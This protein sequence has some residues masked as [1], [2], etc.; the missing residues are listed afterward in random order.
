MYIYLVDD[1]HSA[2]A[3]W[4]LVLSYSNTDGARG[5]LSKLGYITKK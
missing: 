3:K 1:I 5:F 4:K 2:L